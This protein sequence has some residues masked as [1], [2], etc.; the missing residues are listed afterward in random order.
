MNIFRNKK[1]PR[2]AMKVPV[3]TLICP[4]CKL[5]YKKFND[6]TNKEAKLALKQ[7]EKENVLLRKGCPKD[8]NRIKL[9][10]L[11]IFLGFAGGHLYYV[12]RYKMGFMYSCF[13][14]IGLTNALLASFVQGV[15]KLMI[16]QIFT[17]FVLGWGIVL[18]MWL[19]DVANIALN[20]FKIPVSRS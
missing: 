5:N 9:L 15:E 1:C 16:Y 6:A 17:V 11:A 12:G 14:V 2:C 8:V 20:K 10:L 4:D 19:F 3:E 18:F 7:G 13:F